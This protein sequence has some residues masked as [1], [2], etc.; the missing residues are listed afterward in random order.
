MYRGTHLGDRE[1][2]GGGASLSTGCP[3][4]LPQVPTL[5]ARAARVGTYPKSRLSLL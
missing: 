4:F 5:S 1:T 2:T 3:P